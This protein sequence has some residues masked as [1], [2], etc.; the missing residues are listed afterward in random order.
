M[1]IRTVAVGDEPFACVALPD[2]RL[3][4]I[5]RVL[6]G[7]PSDLLSLLAGEQLDALAAAVETGVD[8]DHCVDP[9]ASVL[10]PWTRPRKIL[11][12]G[13][14][15]GA[16]AGDLGE[17]APRTSPASFIKGDHTIVGPGEPIIVPPGIGKVTA[18]AELGLVIGRTCYQVSVEDAMAHVAGV[19]PVLDQTAETV[20]LENPRYLT[21]VKNYPTFF[22]F[23]PDLITLDEVLAHA[24][25][26]DL[27][28]ATIHNGAVHR[29]DTVSRMTF[30]PAEL[31]SF[32]SQVMPFYPGD[33]LSTGTPGAVA[34]EPGDVVRCE[35]GDEL[36]SLTNPVR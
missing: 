10:A 26:A 8:D 32:H 24:P 1:R 30:S 4:R 34:I 12:I 20:L 25:L 35:L 2:G 18:E 17:Q 16:H 29:R 19:V 5:D 11:G 13:L 33:I 23:G 7:G 6:P 31:L 27:R 28:V 21:R 9:N 36:A 14:N 22:S 15:Y 3:A